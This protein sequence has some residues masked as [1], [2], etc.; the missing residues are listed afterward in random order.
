MF[1]GLVSAVGVLRHIERSADGLALRVAAR[2]TRVAIGESIAINGACLTVTGKGRGWFRVSAVTTT[3]TRTLFGEM[4]KGR[5]VNLERALRAG[6]PLGGHLVQGHVDGVATVKAVGRKGGNVVMDL[7]VPAAVARVSVRLGS[8]TVDGVSLT[9][10]DLPRPGIIQVSIIPHTLA[11][12]TLG[13]LVKGSRVHVEADLIGKY[14]D[15]ILKGA[16]GL[17]GRRKPS[18]SSPT[19]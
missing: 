12:T 15:A 14:V 9:I 18:S 17:G 7:R 8:I 19:P 6:D 10:N 3:L 13:G 2:F 4:E 16:R 5:R 1:T 11:V